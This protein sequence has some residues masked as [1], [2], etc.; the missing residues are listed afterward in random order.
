MSRIMLTRLLSAA[1]ALLLTATAAADIFGQSSGMTTDVSNS[2]SPNNIA[3]SNSTPRKAATKKSPSTVGNF[4]V[5]VPSKLNGGPKTNE[6][7]NKA[8]D[9][10]ADKSSAD[11]SGAN[12]DNATPPSPAPPS[13]QGGAAQFMGRAFSRERNAPQQYSAT[14][15]KMVDHVNALVGGFDQGAGFGFGIEFTTAT[16]AELK[17]YE[18]YARAL[19][20]SRLYR[21]GELGARV[22]T[23]KT[24]GEFWFNYTRRTRDNFFDFG[25]L[26][27]RDLET[28]FATE[29]RSYNG[30]FAHRF[31]RRV[32]G[33]LY[34]SFSDT[35][36]F[37]GDDD[38]DPAID[39]LF[40]GNPN[41]TPATNFL[42][43]LQQN[44]R[45]IS[46]GVFSEV[47]MRNNER[48]LTR[49][50]YFYGRFGS[51]DGVDTGASFS[52]F[53]WIETE[54]DGR[55]YIP[56]L[57]NKTSVALRGYAV[58][59]EPKGGSQIPFY[60]QAIFGG[61]TNG[62][63]FSNARFRGNNSVLYSGEIRQT[64]WSQNDEN[65]KGLDIVAFGDVGQVWGDNRSRT[66]P[67]V[68]RNENFDSR[69]YRTGFGGGIQ[70]RLSK[71]VA[72][73]I[74]VGTS[75]ERTLGY[76]SLRPGF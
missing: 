8:T 37:R 67:T 42:P 29:R 21:S 43:G 23:D 19:G 70:Y 68:L 59:R 5:I 76:V 44:V 40:S 61:R 7:T 3:S 47:D 72:F 20:T 30:L 45:L 9:K 6:D 41:V 16:G 31:L 14:A 71:S 12:G 46:Y 22:G 53:A 55:V 27:N 50:G 51:V 38:K 11:S 65:T 25:S 57:S 13:P 24:R 74:E 33:G 1:A 28:N 34:G 62:R 15:I 36:A 32:E 66:D 69:N 64:I 18:F 54:L 48:G 73:R 49:G 56:V 2:A 63:G 39:M 52:D 4:P 35:G 10:A 60:E 17:G 58:L 26:V 75:N